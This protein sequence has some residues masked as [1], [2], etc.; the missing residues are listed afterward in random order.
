MD[1]RVLACDEAGQR[2]SGEVRAHAAAGK[3]EIALA[4]RG[5]ALQGLDGATAERHL[6][7][8]ATFHAV[9]GHRPKPAGEVHLIPCRAQHL[10]AAGARQNQEF[11]TEGGDR[12]LPAELGD[13]SRH[14][15]E[16]HGGMVPEV[17][18]TPARQDGLQV[19]APARGVRITAP[20]MRDRIT[21]DKFNAGAQARSRRRRAL[22]NRPQDAK[23]AAV[24]I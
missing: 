5:R 11:E 2:I 9:R 1:R 23:T 24:S 22:P 20:A 14:V 13:E 21:K 3:N 8:N 10:A 12:P 19:A 7:G 16:I 4:D 15:A 6:M 18:R 17:D